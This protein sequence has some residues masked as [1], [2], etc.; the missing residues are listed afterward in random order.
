VRRLFAAAL[1]ADLVGAA[2]ALLIALRTWQTITTPRPAPLHADVLDVT[3]RSVDAAST[4][5]ALV[6]LAGV[7]AVLA[8][9]GLA[10]RIVGAVLALAGAAMVWRALGSAGAVS[11]T[12]AR[13]FVAD[14]HRTVDVNGVVPHVATHAVWPVLSAVC[15]VLVFA[16][17]VVTAWRGHEWRGMSARYESQ[18]A[19]AEPGGER[20]A[21]ALWTALDRGEDPTR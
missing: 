1:V 4:A 17:G 5:L 13:S 9:R 16:A 12:R 15:G 19:Q 21:T 20:P 7:V 10:R 11:R 8:T 3:G 18:P 6:A 14:H 2:G